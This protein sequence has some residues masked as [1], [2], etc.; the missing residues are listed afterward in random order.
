MATWKLPV[1]D[2]QAQI[3]KERGTFSP[4]KRTKMLR[5]Q[6]NRRNS[7]AGD[8]NVYHASLVEDIREFLATS[9]DYQGKVEGGIVF[10]RPT[11]THVFIARLL[12]TGP[13]SREAIMATA[14]QHGFYGPTVSFT[15]SAMSRYQS[16]VRNGPMFSMRTAKVYA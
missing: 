2:F 3:A 8:L 5:T 6:F 15:L 13:K 12:A 7:N 10:F 11:P 16:I 9:L 4:S 14:E 1:F